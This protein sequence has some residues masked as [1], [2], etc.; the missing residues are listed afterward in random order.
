MPCLHTHDIL[1]Q[2]GGVGNKKYRYTSMVLSGAPGKTIFAK[3]GF[4]CKSNEGHIPG[5]DQH[6]KL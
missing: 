5:P 6:W 1:H 4:C 2:V 3:Q